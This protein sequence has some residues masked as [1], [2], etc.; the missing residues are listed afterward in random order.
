MSEKRQE[1]VAEDTRVV[2][3]DDPLVINE[4][5]A[6]FAH[7]IIEGGEIVAQV[8]TKTTFRVLEKRS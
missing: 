7:V 6:L 4:P 2:T 3:P 5:E 1:A 8:P